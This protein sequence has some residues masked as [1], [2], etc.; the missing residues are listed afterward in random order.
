MQ[1]MPR[2]ATP[3]ARV[4]FATSLRLPPSTRVDAVVCL[5][6][7]AAPLPV[8]CQFRIEWNV[9]VSTVGAAERTGK[10][11]WLLERLAAGE[12]AQKMVGFR[13]RHRL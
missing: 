6:L 8:A 4:R 5:E 9:V 1:K 12:A 10:R 7:R 2:A 11:K 3:W 13:R